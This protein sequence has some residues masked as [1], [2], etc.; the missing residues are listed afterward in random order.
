MLAI[1]VFSVTSLVKHVST[2]SSSVAMQLLC[3]ELYSEELAL[4]R[5]LQ[6]GQQNKDGFSGNARD[7]VEEP[8]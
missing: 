8:S 2:D 5:I 1:P 4:T 3:G 7:G 6:I